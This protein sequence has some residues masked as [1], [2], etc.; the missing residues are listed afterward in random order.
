MRNIDS[1]KRATLSLFCI[2]TLVFSLSAFAQVGI[3]T[4]SPKEGSLLDVDANNKGIY[5]PQVSLTSLGSLNPITGVTL[6]ANAYGLIVYN[7]NA[8]TGGPGLFTWT[9]ATWVAVGDG[10][11]TE[12]WARLGNAGTNPGTGV[13]QNYLG[14]TDPKDLI[15]GTQGSERMRILSDGRASINN[16]A[17]VSVDRFTVTGNPGEFAINGYSSTNGV[18]MYGENTGSGYGV[19]GN[20]ANIGVF[21]TGAAGIYGDSGGTGFGVIGNNSG[22]GVGVTGY[23]TGTGFGIA[24]DNDATGIGVFGNTVNSGNAIWGQNTG[25][26]RGVIG[27]NTA[28]GTGVQGQ[29][30]TGVGVFGTASTAGGYGGYSRNTST[31]GIGFIASGANAGLLTVPGSGA[32][33]ILNG[34]YGAMGFSTATNGTGIGG[35]GNNVGNLYTLN[36]GS[37]LAGTGSSTGVYGIATATSGVRQGGYFTMNKTGS[38]TPLA[39]DDPIAIV[40]GYN[41]TDYFGGYF[42]GNQDNIPGGAGTN[43][44]EDYAYVGIRTGGTT[45]KILGTGSNSTMINDASGNKRILFSPE[46]PEILFEDYGTG[47]LVN[48]T[49]NVVLDPLLNSIIHVSTNHPLKVFIQLEGECNGVYVTNKSAQGFTVKELNGGRSNVSFSWHIVGNRE[50]TKL[51]NGEV[52]SKH[53]GVRFPIGPDKI[54][55]KE[56][57]KNTSVDAPNDNL[58][59]ELAQPKLEKKSIDK[60]NFKDNS[61]NTPSKTPNVSKNK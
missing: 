43:A 28:N 9:G 56:I 13:G 36:S 22:T 14:T 1:S 42:D 10:N 24:G 44:G 55:S 60:I 23:S 38:V 4:T 15:L 33:A 12:A 48:G 40:A 51:P 11:G 37:G 39:A 16:A 46:A 19:W 18:G 35:V 2:L 41:G 25:T 7:T 50:D 58:T 49:A 5:I 26:G 32:G 47:Q 29:T 61:T 6:P 34:T 8:L 17:P 54:S 45:Y 3:N 59:D 31:T 30:V 21:G 52:F 53:V 57:Q 27:L 20:A